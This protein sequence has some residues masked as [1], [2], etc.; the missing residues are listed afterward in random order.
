[1]DNLTNPLSQILLL[2]A[3]NNRHGITLEPQRAKV[4]LSDVQDIVHMGVPSS[5]KSPW[6]SAAGGI[7]RNEEDAK[8]AAI[9]E[10]IE[11]YSA[12]LIELPL[13]H[14][15]SITTD[16]IVTADKWCLFTKEHRERADFPF[17]NIYS[18]NCMYTNVYDL[19]TNK[20]TWIPQPLV[21]LRD[22]Y[23]TGIPTSS[24]LAAGPSSYQALLRAIQEL[25][26]RDALMMTWLHS[27]PARS[28]ETPTFYKSQVKELNG[29]MWAFDLTPDYSPFPVIAV[30]GGIP[31]KGKWR[32]SLGV[33]CRETW[34]AALD[35]AYLEWNQGVL[36]AGI[37]EKYVDTS[38][39]KDPFKLK[40][41]DEH[42]IYYSIHPEE[43]NDL[44]FF[45]NRDQIC[46][47][48]IRG[49]EMTCE[50]ALKTIKSSLNKSSINLYYRDITTIDACQLG[51][52]VVRVASPDLAPIFAHQEWPLIDKLESKLHSRYSW[53]PKNTDFPNLMPHPLG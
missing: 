24:G 21:A 13:R 48:S 25:I 14:R 18:D 44:P 29:E 7:G 5:V 4:S 38:Y 1:M 2:Q 8:L 22:D 40:S 32:Y 20:E 26:E 50:Q 23:K 47:L 19:Q 45:K 11:R 52:R 16:R 41:F 9:G 42:A 53:A 36:F 27:I 33:A 49:K 46:E 30:A 17:K 51:I 34:G 37:Y 3:P 39:L 28:I 43:W 10:A 35:K 6:E 15:D 12:T 31:K